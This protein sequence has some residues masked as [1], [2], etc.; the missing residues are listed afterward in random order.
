MLS[1]TQKRKCYDAYGTDEPELRRRGRSDG[2]EYDYSRGFE[3]K[4]YVCLMSR[5]EAFHA[6]CLECP[7]NILLCFQGPVHN[8][9]CTGSLVVVLSC[10][11]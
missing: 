10:C 8:R 4:L 11:C 9:S 6:S 2:Y 3:G 1:D 7:V 5:A